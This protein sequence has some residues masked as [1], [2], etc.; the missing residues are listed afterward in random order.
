MSTEEELLGDINSFLSSNIVNKETLNFLMKLK[1]K[2]LKGYDMT[3]KQNKISDIETTLR[4]IGKTA[5]IE[6]FYTLKED[7][8]GDSGNIISCMMSHGGAKKENSAR[9]KASI[10]RKIFKEGM[11]IEALKNIISSNRVK[12]AIRNKALIILQKEEK[13]L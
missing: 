9:T 10:G 6:C 13:R 11:E 8:D 5:F 3:T 4:G 7:Q 2:I 12:E 1:Q